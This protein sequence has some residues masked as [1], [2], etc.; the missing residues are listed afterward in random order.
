M[1]TAMCEQVDVHDVKEDPAEKKWGC[2][3]VTRFEVGRIIAPTKQEADAIWQR[4]RDLSDTA[5]G[6]VNCVWQTW[7]IWHAANGSAAKLKAHF[8]AHAKWKAAGPETRGEKPV[9]PVSAM[10]KECSKA[11]YDAC[12]AA[13]PEIEASARE[14]IRNEVVGKI[15]NLKAANGSLPGWIA[16]LF[17]HQSAP[18]TTRGNPIPFSTKNSE[19]EPPANEGD[20][21]KLHLKI[22]RLEPAA[23]KRTGTSIHDVCTLVTNARKME[24]QRA[25]LKKIARGEYKFCGSKLVMDG[26]K[27]Y[28]LICYRQPNEPLPDFD[29]SRVAF[30]FPAKE[31][32]FLLTI[33]GDPIEAASEKDWLAFAPL[34]EAGGVGIKGRNRSPGH[35]GIRV[36]PQQRRV[37]VARRLSMK[38]GYRIAAGSTRKGRGRDTAI[39]P[40]HKLTRAWKNVVKN[41]THGVTKDVVEQCVA[42]GIGTLVY[43]Q[44]DASWRDTR[45]LTTAGKSD[46]APE[47]SGWDWTQI[48]TFLKYK[49]DRSGVRLQIIKCDL[50]AAP[51]EDVSS[52]ST[53][54]LD[55]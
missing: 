4:W 2:I 12:A 42:N 15:K 5:R 3:R 40:W 33:A 19:I 10:N 23:G 50:S 8:A 47:A 43:F 41:Y 25:N 49:C 6:V 31:R 30:L 16:I 27:W 39:M 17:Y 7:L 32:P 20:A 26:K 44:P 29:E 51:T 9:W 55:G 21:F 48:G 35:A 28:A 1:T 54:A 24:S 34:L 38:H 11:T 22:G 46:E 53:V 37:L 18:S 14:L 13:F 45:F 52:S 36:I